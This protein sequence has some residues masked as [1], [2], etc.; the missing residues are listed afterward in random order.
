MG[1]GDG[2]ALEGRP[3][4]IIVGLTEGRRADVLEGLAEGKAVGFK[5]G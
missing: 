2:F 5:V 3:D 1:K 4:G